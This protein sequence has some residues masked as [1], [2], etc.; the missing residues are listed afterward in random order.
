NIDLCE[1]RVFTLDKTPKEILSYVM[2]HNPERYFEMVDWIELEAD[3][4][5][6]P[7]RRGPAK[8]WNARLMIGLILAVIPLLLLLIT[9]RGAWPA[10]PLYLPL[11][12]AMEIF[13]VVVALMIFALGWHSVGP[14]MSRSMVVCVLQ[15]IPRRGSARPWAHVVIPWH[16][17]LRHTQFCGERDRVLADVAPTVCPLFAGCRKR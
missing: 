5:S 16:A 2:K 12:T 1:N 15:R 10:F 11:H 4:K 13:A 8:A 9:P 3:A 17:G 14:R 6:M 7:G